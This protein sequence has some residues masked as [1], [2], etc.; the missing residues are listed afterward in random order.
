MVALFL[1]R[2]LSCLV[3]ECLDAQN[4]LQQLLRYPMPR[5]EVRRTVVSDRDA[6]ILIL[7]NKYLERKVDGTAWGREH[8]RRSR[9][10]ISEDQQLGRRHCHP[11]LRGFTTVI[12]DGKQLYGF[13]VQRRHQG[14]NRLV[15]RVSTLPCDQTVA[16]IRCHGYPPRMSTTASPITQLS[17]SLRVPRSCHSVSKKLRKHCR[18]QSENEG[19]PLTRSD[20]VQVVFLELRAGKRHIFNRIP[21]CGRLHKLNRLRRV[22]NAGSEPVRIVA[23]LP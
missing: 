16:V 21:G 17:R 8:E 19:R 6:A 5:S 20:C 13:R 18:C 12:D 22:G 1:G 3:D 2:L 10:W 11:R 7:P 15:D 14:Y 4:I 23:L 9:L